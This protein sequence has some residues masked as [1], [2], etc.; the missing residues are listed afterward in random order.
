MTRLTGFQKKYLR[1]LAHG[2]KPVVHIG[3][4]GVTDSVIRSTHEALD[5]HE[6]IKIRFVDFKEKDQKITLSNLIEE[7]T[8]SELIG[9]IGHIGVFYRPNEDPEKRRITLPAARA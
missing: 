9:M 2:R 7:R 6:L 1:G 3:R 5:T 4:Q 8:G